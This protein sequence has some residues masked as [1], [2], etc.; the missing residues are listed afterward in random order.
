LEVAL[1]RTASSSC[2][3]GMALSAHAQIEGWAQIAGAGLPCPSSTGE[4][5]NGA[6]PTGCTQ[7]WYVLSEATATPRHHNRE[8]SGFS[9]FSLPSPRASQLQKDG[10]ANMSPTSPLGP[11][12]KPDDLGDEHDLVWLSL[13]GP[14]LFL[15]ASPL[16]PFAFVPL[17]S[18]LVFAAEYAQDL[19]CITGQREGVNLVQLVFLLPDGRWRRF[20]AQSLAIQLSDHQQREDWIAHL[21]SA[22]NSL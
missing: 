15:S 12:M 22:C 6:T 20:R 7:L 16:E 17:R 3:D 8:G 14:V 10:P 11:M 13:C 19:L 18:M 5:V 9:A 1:P 21:D 2:M 4:E